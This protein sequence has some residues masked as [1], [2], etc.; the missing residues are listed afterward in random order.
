MTMSKRKTKPK[1]NIPDATS[2][3]P[4]VANKGKSRKKN[5][6]SAQPPMPDSA[7]SES[8][9][10]ESPNIEAPSAQLPTP[11][12]RKAPIPKSPST[13]AT[14]KVEDQFAKAKE[15]QEATTMTIKATAKFLGCCTNHVRW[16]IKHERLQGVKIEIMENVEQWFIT[17]KSAQEYLDSDQAKGG[18]PR[19][20]SRSNK[21]KP[22]P[23]KK[24]KTKKVLV[25]YRSQKPKM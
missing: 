9:Q 19:G 6:A 11:D 17:K 4:E 14:K 24:G 10:S 5:A 7:S 20:R 23:K 3:Q 2:A 1:V 18:W 21:P 12:T 16:L 25:K 15:T 8:A 13:Q 22:K